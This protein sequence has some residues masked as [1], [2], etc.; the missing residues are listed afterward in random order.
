MAETSPLPIPIRL[1][2]DRSSQ[3]V[4]REQT[5]NE[6]VFAVVGHI[7]AG[8]ST[9]AKDLK[10]ELEKSDFQVELLKSKDVITKWAAD[11]GKPVPELAKGID[12]VTAL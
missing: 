10:K 11:H 5:S 6:F 3:S 2:N 8:V 7:G 9:I 1:S 4:I 12:Y